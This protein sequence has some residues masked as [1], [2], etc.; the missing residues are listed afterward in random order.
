MLYC[1][2]TYSSKSNSGENVLENFYN[3]RVGFQC[4]T[5]WSTLWILLIRSTSL[6]TSTKSFYN[7][8]LGVMIRVMIRNKD[9]CKDLINI[10]YII[11][12]RSIALV[13]DFLRKKGSICGQVCQSDKKVSLSTHDERW[14]QDGIWYV[15]DDQNCR[16]R[17]DI[18]KVFLILFFF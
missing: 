4:H 10:K 16:V 11:Q 18:T 2:S 17:L 7:L 1:W 13:Y 5:Q 9:I 8:K 12:P 14:T 6:S 15:S 3:L